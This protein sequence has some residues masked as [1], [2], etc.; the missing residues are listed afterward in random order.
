MKIKRGGSSSNICI[1]KYFYQAHEVW[2]QTR[3]EES[4][5]QSGPIAAEANKTQ[6]DDDETAPQQ[7]THSGHLQFDPIDS[8]HLTSMKIVRHRVIKLL[9]GSKNNMHAMLNMLITIVSY[10]S[11]RR[12]K[13]CLL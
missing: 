8:R 13:F 11:N 12:T 4:R 2:K 9:E 7:S 10:R 6:Q 3:E 5:I 1:H